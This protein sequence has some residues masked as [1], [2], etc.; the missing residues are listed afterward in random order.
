MP[1]YLLDSN[2]LSDI[3]RNP[4]GRTALRHQL[5]TD[6]P[7]NEILV[8][9]VTACELRYGVA[10]KG[11]K[12][13]GERIEELLAGVRVAPLELGADQA[14][15]ELRADLERKG[16]LIGPNDMLIAAHALA[17]GA[18][19]ITDNTREFRRVKGLKVE[20]WL[21]G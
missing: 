13:L 21:R 16:Q 7:E 5:I 4:G 15:G 10:K 9:I 2:T 14:Y 17:L 11:S 12:R 18:I 1:A 19:L 20:N 8:S 3:F 6:D